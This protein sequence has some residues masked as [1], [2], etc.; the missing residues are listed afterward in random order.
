MT[1]HKYLFKVDCDKCKDPFIIALRLQVYVDPEWLI[2]SVPIKNICPK[3]KV[4]NHARTIVR[5]LKQPSTPYKHP[6][7]TL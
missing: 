1:K 4:Q 7:N 2:K 3:C 5:S 6:R